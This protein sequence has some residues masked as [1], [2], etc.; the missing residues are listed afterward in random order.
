MARS[1][2]GPGT[3]NA[4]TGAEARELARDFRVRCQTHDYQYAID[5]EVRAFLRMNHQC[6]AELLDA[7]DVDW[8]FCK[9]GGHWRDDIV[10]YE[11]TMSR[12]EVPVTDGRQAHPSDPVARWF[13]KSS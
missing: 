13:I 3:D 9:E 11:N 2:P 5:P 12:V 7:A 10:A 4:A 6:Q 8:I 1:A